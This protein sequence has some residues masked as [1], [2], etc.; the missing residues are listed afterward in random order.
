MNIPHFLARADQRH[1]AIVN[2]AERITA[3]VQ[4]TH[5]SGR[6]AIIHPCTDGRNAWQLTRMDDIGPYSDSR[7]NNPQELIVEALK[8][9]FRHPEYERRDEDAR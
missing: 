9:G 1:R 4:L 5:K 8:E 3:P 2:A 6:Y 7:R